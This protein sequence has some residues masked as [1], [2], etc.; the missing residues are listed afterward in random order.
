[1]APDLNPVD[2]WARPDMPATVNQSVST[3]ATGKRGRGDNYDNS[4]LLCSAISSATL[5][6]PSKNEYCTNKK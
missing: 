5:A 1:M 3:S 4:G 2:G 6:S